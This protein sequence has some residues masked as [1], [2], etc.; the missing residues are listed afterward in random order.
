MKNF[1]IKTLG[2]KT[3]QIESDLISEK[4]ESLNFLK[5]EDFE[6]A[7]IFILNSCSVTSNADNDALKL[8][9]K[10]K[11]ENPPAR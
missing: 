4:L 9:K 11:R 7:D 1:C 3:N 6:N 10:V 8:L 2:C 5:V